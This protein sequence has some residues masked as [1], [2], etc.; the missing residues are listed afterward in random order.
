MSQVCWG[1]GRSLAGR[2]RHRSIVTIVSA[3]TLGTLRPPT[4]YLGTHKL[5]SNEQDD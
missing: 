5:N 4:E 3:H 2:S 1:P